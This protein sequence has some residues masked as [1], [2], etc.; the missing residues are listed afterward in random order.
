MLWDPLAQTEE[1]LELHAGAM[2]MNHRGGEIRPQWLKLWASSSMSM[3]GYDTA[4]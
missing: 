3:C 2:L 1:A 4:V